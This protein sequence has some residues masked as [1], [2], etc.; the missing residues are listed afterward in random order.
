MRWTYVAM[1]FPG[2]LPRQAHIVCQAF[3]PVFRASYGRWWTD[4]RRGRSLAWR[5]GRRLD[6]GVQP[7][8]V[9]AVFL[10]DPPIYKALMP[11]L[12]DTIF[13]PFCI[14]LRNLLE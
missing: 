10:E 12:K 14:E 7:D 1:A 5:A 2:A 13:H 8:E 6:G 3:P 4:P 9:R 11:A